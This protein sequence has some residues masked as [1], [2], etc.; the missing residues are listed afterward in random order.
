MNALPRS[1]TVTARIV[2]GFATLL[3]TTTCTVV[4]RPAAE[5]PPPVAVSRPTPAIP[6]IQPPARPW[7]IASAS[8]QGAVLRGVAPSGTV[9]LSLEGNAVPIADDG[10]FIIAFDRDAPSSETLTATFADG[11]SDSRTIAIAPGR[12]DI[13]NIDASLTGG[14]SSAEFQRRRA[15]ELARINAARAQ[16]NAVDGWRQAFIWPTDGRITG[17]FGSQRIY[18]GTPASYHSG[19]DMAGAT[20]TVFRA[21]ADGVVILAADEPF[22]LEGRLLMIDHGHGL[23]SAFLHC[24]KLYVTEG[25]QVRQGQPLGEIGSTGRAT[26]PH[27]H[28]SMK[29]AGARIDPRKLARPAR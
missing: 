20:G 16:A 15:P 7:T 13:Q 2:A 5:A 14:V 23:N 8:E 12:W 10:A 19:V 11:H 6:I 4:P 1:A 17:V 26:G 24:S 9:A 18:R 29:L 25:Q 3:L 21:P 28:W 27:L 22:T